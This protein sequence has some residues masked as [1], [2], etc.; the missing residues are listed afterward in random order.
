MIEVRKYQ[1]SSNDLIGLTSLLT[2]LSCSDEK[3]MF[4]KFLQDPY[5]YINTY[6]NQ[7]GYDT[8]IALKDKKMVGF[9]VG[10]HWNNEIYNVVMLYVDPEHRRSGIAHT[11][12]CSL[13]GLARSRGYEKIISKVRVNN[14]SSILLNTKSKWT[15]TIDKLY[16]EYYFWFTKELK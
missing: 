14:T 1:E 9:M 13:T 3:S 12:K 6:I 11:L 5:Y 4:D 10:E 7:K 2:K 15:R 16:P 8:I